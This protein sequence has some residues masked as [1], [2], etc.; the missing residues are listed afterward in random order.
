MASKEIWVS[1]SCFQDEI[2]AISFMM[3]VS[4]I[5]SILF[6]LIKVTSKIFTIPKIAVSLFIRR[7]DILVVPVVLKHVYG[8][9]PEAFHEL[10]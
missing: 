9:L 5:I 6:M 1:H 8:Q 10:K 7:D 3:I 2:S 4:Q